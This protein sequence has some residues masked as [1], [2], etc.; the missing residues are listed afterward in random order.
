MGLF[1]FF[2]K[3]PQAPKGPRIG[4]VTHYFGGIGVAIIKFTKA[5]PV[6][7]TIHIKG[8]T[9]DFTETIG[10]LQYDHREITEAKKGQEVGVKVSEKVREG[11]EVYGA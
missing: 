9:T 11:D 3:S 7:T 5:V 10:S 1:S 8:A 2:K 6:G 4:E